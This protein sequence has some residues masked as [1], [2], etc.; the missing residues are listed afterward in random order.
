MCVDD[1]RG[2]LLNAAFLWACECVILSFKIQQQ[3]HIQ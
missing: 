1:A 3:Q 2:T